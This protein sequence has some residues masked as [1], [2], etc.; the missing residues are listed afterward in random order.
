MDRK[1]HQKWVCNF[2]NRKKG[3]GDSNGKLHQWTFEDEQKSLAAALEKI[4]KQGSINQQK[5]YL[6]ALGSSSLVALENYF[7]TTQKESL[8]TSK[9]DST[10]HFQRIFIEK[11]PSQLQKIK[12]QNA[13][14]LILF[15]PKLDFF[16]ANYSKKAISNLKEYNLVLE[17]KKFF[18]IEFQNDIVRVLRELQNELER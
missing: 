2:T 7:L 16:D 1:S 9:T 17:S 11:L 3:V 13:D 18:W 14:S 12:N 4:K 15:F 10:I 8:L 5:V 6:I